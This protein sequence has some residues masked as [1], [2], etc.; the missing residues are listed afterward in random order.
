[1]NR[2]N[3]R[4]RLFFL[5]ARTLFPCVLA[6]IRVRQ[7][8]VCDATAPGKRKI[9]IIADH[10]LGD[11]VHQIP[12]FEALRRAFPKEQNHLAVVVQSSIADLVRQMP[13]F[14]EVLVGDAR[15]RHPIFWILGGHLWRASSRR[16]D[17]LIDPVR[18]RVIGHDWLN[19]VWRPVRSVAYDSE[20]NKQN[21]P[22]VGHWQQRCGDRLWSRLIPSKAGRPVEADFQSFVDAVAN[23]GTLVQ[24]SLT[25]S[26]PSSRSTNDKDGFSIVLVPG[27]NASFRRWSIDSFRALVSRLLQRHSNLQFS[28]VGNDSEVPLGDALAESFPDQVENF[29]GKTD[30]SSLA[31]SLSPNEGRRIVLANET[32][33]AHLAA[34]QG[35]RTIVILGGGDF[36]AL[37]PAPHRS[38]VRALFKKRDCFG[39]GWQC[40]CADLNSTVA[41]CVEDVRVEDVVLAVEEWL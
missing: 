17:M 37:F 9:L 18:M 2:T 31:A 10:R 1:M 6:A 13:W 33:T 7:F 23:S 8:F 34:V 41:P 16:F 4:D 26:C 22:F 11:T 35:T 30:L 27:A 29:C 20:I 24:P 28:V 19:R 36:G 32:G 38:N 15:E 12:L 14:D 40:R 39:C 25:W 3:L 21:F 5:L